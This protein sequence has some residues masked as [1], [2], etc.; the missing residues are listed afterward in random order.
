MSR[1]NW[2]ELMQRSALAWLPPLVQARLAGQPRG[3]GPD[4]LQRP[5]SLVFVL[6]GRGQTVEL[7]NPHTKQDS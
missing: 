1:N 4:I 7:V 2:L 3:G 5:Y 6:G